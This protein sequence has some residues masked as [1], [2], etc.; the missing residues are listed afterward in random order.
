MPALLPFAVGAVLILAVLAA[1]FWPIIMPRRFKKPIIEKEQ[2]RYT[3]E[4]SVELAEPV[5]KKTVLEPVPELPRS[6][7]MDRLVLMVRDPYWLYAY[8]E[9]TATKMEEIS[10]KLGPLIWDNSKPVLRVYDITGVDFNGINAKRFFDCSLNDYSDNWY[11]NVAEAN[12]SYC[13]DLG[14]LF[15]DGSF[16]TLLRSNIVTTPRDALSDR[17]DEEWMWIEGLYSK[18]RMGLSSP[19]I[20]EE[21]S[22]RMGMLPLGISS[23]GFNPDGR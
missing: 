9:I 22:E 17:M 11:I 4:Y 6:Y 23:P 5:K 13:V 14:R 7:G 16:V 10:A 3:E 18:H 1:V 8:W 21:I 12:R 2:Q 19:L 15:P 20:I